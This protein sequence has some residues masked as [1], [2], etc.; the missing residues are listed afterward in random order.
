MRWPDFERWK[1]RHPKAAEHLE[2]ADVLVDQ[3]RGRYTAWYRI[4]VNLQHVP[5]KLRPAQE[6]LDPDDEPVTD[7]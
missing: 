5:A 1:K 3:M 7:A 4:R 2:P 6:P